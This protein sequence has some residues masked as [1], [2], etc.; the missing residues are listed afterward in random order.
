MECQDCWGLTPVQGVDDSQMG[1]KC[2][3]LLDHSRRASFG[4]TVPAA[5]VKQW[6]RVYGRAEAQGRGQGCDEVNR[7]DGARSEQSGD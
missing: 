2:P 7:R 5:S 4:Q 1:E 3:P 6:L